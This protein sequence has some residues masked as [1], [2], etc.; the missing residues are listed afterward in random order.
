MWQ[1]PSEPHNLLSVPLFPH[2]LYPSCKCV[3][4]LIKLFLDTNAVVTAQAV[5]LLKEAY[6]ITRIILS[7]PFE[8]GGA[9]KV[10][11]T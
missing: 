1:S 4:L 9:I 11:M 7:K 6:G 8:V 10:I 3:V 5:V 2:L